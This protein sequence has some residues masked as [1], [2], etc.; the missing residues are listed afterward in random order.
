MHRQRIPPLASARLANC[1]APAAPRA[2]ARRRELIHSATQIAI[3]DRPKRHQYCRRRTSK[4]QKCGGSPRQSVGVP[5]HTP[6][7]AIT[8]TAKRTGIRRSGIFMGGWPT[9]TPPPSPTGAPHLVLFEMWVQRS[10]LLT[11]FNSNM[12]SALCVANPRANVQ[13]L[14]LKPYGRQA[15]T[16][17]RVWPSPLCDV[18]LL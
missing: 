15:R 6:T 2:R 7:D 14:L 16:A 11:I 8:S 9:S 10:P 17:V 1:F 12:V 4:C 18:F 5:C 13:V 3:K